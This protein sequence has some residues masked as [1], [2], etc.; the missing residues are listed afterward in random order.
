MHAIRKILIV[1]AVTTLAASAG[2]AAFADPSS[3]PS[4]V[5]NVGVNCDA[6]FDQLT[7][8]F[9]AM[10]PEYP[11]AC[12]DSTGK[13]P[14]VTKALNPSDTSCEL[15][16]PAGSS[17]AIAALNENQTD[18]NVV[19]GQSKIY[20]IDWAESHR[21]PNTTTFEDA[22]DA[23]VRDG[24][25]WSFPKVSGET[26]PQ[27]KTLTEAQLAAVYTCEDTNWDQVGGKDAPIGV[28]LPQSGSDTRATWLQELGIAANS[29]PCW[30]NGTVTVSGTTDVIEE[31]TG[32]SAGN[33]AQF[34][35][36][37]DFGTTCA[38][39]CAPADDIFPYSI[40]D[41]IAQGAETDGVGGHATAVWGHGNLKLG[42]TDNLKGVAKVAITKNSSGQP[43]I[44]PAWN[45]DFLA[46]VYGV[47]R[48]GCFVS[49]DP[50]STEVC[51]PSTTPPAGGT[52]YPVYEAVGLKAF[53]G[54][55]AEDGWICSNATAAADIVSYG[56]TKL[57]DCGALTA[58]D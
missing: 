42:E 3:T 1:V 25:A 9:D 48:N 26:N 56:L 17:A 54:T 12:F 6:L 11:V 22:F 8:D 53:F 18:P 32:L 19:S 58:G 5:T 47:M 50:T 14:I 55:K 24:L 35:K 31:N 16:R 15:P 21:P 57:V 44:N 4:L 30:Q 41:Y 46:V 51:L 23:L 34:T 13:S 7:V 52:A 49:S 28:V 29:E 36:T 2:G 10:H 20:C 37:Q 43:V 45:P 39:G 27:P 40:G 38:S 33:V